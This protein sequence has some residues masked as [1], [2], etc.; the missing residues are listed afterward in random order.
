MNDAWDGWHQHGNKDPE[1]CNNSFAWFVS[2]ATMSK[3]FRGVCLGGA[4]SFAITIASV[5]TRMATQSQA[6]LQIFCSTGILTGS[7]LRS[8]K[9][10]NVAGCEKEP[11]LVVWLC[12]F[13]WAQLPSL[14]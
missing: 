4:L 1:S 3:A 6:H 9:P 7:P 12:G 11:I 5:S 8:R 2:L 13:Q 14:P 10:P